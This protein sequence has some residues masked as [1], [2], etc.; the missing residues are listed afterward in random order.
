MTTTALDGAF[1]AL[2]TAVQVE[3]AVAADLLEHLTRIRLLLEAGGFEPLP[4]R[5][6]QLELVAARLDAASRHRRQAT[7]DLSGALGVGDGPDAFAQ[8]IARA[9]TPWREQL[10][11]HRAAL[12]ELNERIEQEATADRQRAERELDALHRR[13][14]P[15]GEDEA[16]ATGP[17]SSG[18]R[19]L[20]A[21]LDLATLVTELRV[22]EIV[23]ESIIDATTGIGPLGWRS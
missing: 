23:Y 2:T 14:A 21:D 17:A 6:T 1:G 15:D 3:R 20:A 8:V 22:R 10:A 7:R 5:L 19:R 18:E 16:R 9:P 13:M 11:D 4:E 12:R